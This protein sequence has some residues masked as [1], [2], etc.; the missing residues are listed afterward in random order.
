MK[1]TA[2]LALAL[3]AAI[4]LVLYLSSYL[5][6]Q[7]DGLRLS[8][9]ASGLTG[10]SLSIIYWRI[11]RPLDR[12]TLWMRGI[13]S[14]DPGNVFPVRARALQS[15][16]VEANRLAQSLAEA[17]AAA[18]LEARLRH[19]REALWTAERL[20]EHVRHQLEGRPLFLV[21]NREPYEHYRKGKDIEVRTP[22]SGLV[23]GLEPILRACGGTWIAHASGDADAEVVD[24]Q[25]KVRVPPHDPQYTLKRVWL[26]E[27]QAA[28]Y[29]Y[30]F[31]NEGLW[32][33][34]H[35]AH[36]RPIF[37]PDDWAQYR[38]V[39]ERF[40]QALLAE[41][42]GT[43]EPF[44]LIQDYHF[45]LLPKLIKTYRPDARVAIFWHIPWPNPEAFDICPWQTDILDGMLGADL[46][47]FHI[48]FHC[49]NFLETVDRTLESQVDWERFA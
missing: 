38:A 6:V 22:A 43:E 25:G 48:Q 14:G 30:G 24:A 34:C 28:G 13:R 45:A 40:A 37:E 7:S 46:I 49:N 17:R 10:V 41:M 36:A 12:L 18:T 15:V 16:V 47:G 3:A 27:E 31:S 8:L 26:S 5:H 35:I 19:T 11:A 42:R 2:R 1:I 44:V 23:T 39:N 4:T 20:K 9:M 29:Y 33:L 21:A 32:P